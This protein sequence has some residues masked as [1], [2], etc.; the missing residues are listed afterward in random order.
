VEALG[1]GTLPA[2]RVVTGRVLTSRAYEGQLARIDDVVVTAV[3]AQS[4]ATS[5][6]NVTAR[7][8]DGTVFT[9]RAEGRTNVDAPA[10]TV[11]QTYD[12]VGI[13]SVFSGVGQ[14]KPRSTADVTAG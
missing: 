14:I 10:F 6:F 3:A 7:A 1:A 13:L 4:S 9:I 2:P 8:P 5:S 11:G 12:I